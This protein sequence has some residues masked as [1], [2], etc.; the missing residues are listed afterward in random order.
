MN[1]GKMARAS[2]TLLASLFYSDA[3]MHG[4]CVRADDDA[5]VLRNAFA[6]RCAARASA[7]AAGVWSGRLPDF[8]IVGV[9]KG[10]TSAHRKNMARHPDIAMAG[11]E[12][13]WFD[14]RAKGCAAMRRTHGQ[15]VHMCCT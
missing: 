6:S 1:H 13:H 11:R 15:D 14:H 12:Q 5:H 2:A 8:I 7:A 3:G 9:M 4:T 10:G